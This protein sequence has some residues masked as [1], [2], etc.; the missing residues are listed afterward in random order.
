MLNVRI[1]AEVVSVGEMTGA[2]N[3]D[4]IYLLGPAAY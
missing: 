1:T 3:L 4:L 2:E